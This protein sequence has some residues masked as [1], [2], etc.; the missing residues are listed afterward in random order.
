[1]ITATAE[2]DELSMT[3]ALSQ[4]VAIARFKAYKIMEINF[5]SGNTADTYLEAV[6]I[7]LQNRID[8]IVCEQLAAA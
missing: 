5:N 4:L 2:M 7:H 3:V 1:V 6:M 8:K